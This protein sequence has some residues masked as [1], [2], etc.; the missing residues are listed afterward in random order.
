MA[1]LPRP[2][3][4]FA[5]QATEVLHARERDRGQAIDEFVHALAAKGD[6]RADRHAIAQL[7]RGD[8]LARLRLDRLLAGDRREVGDSR[9]DLLGVGDS[10]ANAHVDHDLVERRD[11]QAVRVAELL[12]QLLA[13]ALRR[14]SDLRRG[15]Y[16]ASAIDRL[17][18]ALGEAHLAALARQS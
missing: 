11:L 7:E 18:G 15:V 8:R 3:N 6:L 1:K 13:D 9:A 4:D 12:G 17:P 16:L 14:T 2:S 10:F 5:V